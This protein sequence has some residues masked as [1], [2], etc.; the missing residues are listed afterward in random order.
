M[1][2]LGWP[3]G[4]ATAAQRWKATK[5]SEQLGIEPPDWTDEKWTEGATSKLIGQL[6]ELETDQRRSSNGSH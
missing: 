5:L 3:K 2:W 1:S 4:P 6:L